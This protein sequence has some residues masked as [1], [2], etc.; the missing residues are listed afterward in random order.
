MYRNN[1]PVRMNSIDDFG[2]TV[3]S[4]TPTP[5]DTDGDRDVDRADLA[6]LTRNYGQMSD[7]T[8]SHGD[9]NDDHMVGLA[10]LNILRANFGTGISRSPVPEPALGGWAALTLA[11][12][13]V[14]RRCRINR[15]SR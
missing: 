14:R 8:V 4:S 10:D 3:G 2:F 13:L 15:S 1:D 11:A 7:A 9:F 5:G 12:L 6:Q